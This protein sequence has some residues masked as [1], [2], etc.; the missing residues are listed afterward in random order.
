MRYTLVQRIKNDEQA[1]KMIIT[2]SLL[3]NSFL[4][5]TVVLLAALAAGIAWLH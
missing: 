4:F 5:G 3:V 2:S 1:V